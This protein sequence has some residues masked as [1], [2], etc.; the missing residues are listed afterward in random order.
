MFTCLTFHLKEIWKETEEQLVEKVRKL[1]QQLKLIT[2]KN[3]KDYEE[4]HNKYRK[5]Q[6]T[7][8]KLDNEIK[9]IKVSISCIFFFL[10]Y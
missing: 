3:S 6:D 8:K 5:A 1:D 7:I 10:N 4:L 9:I 2:V